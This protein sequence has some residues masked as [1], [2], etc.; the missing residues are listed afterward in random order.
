MPSV[1]P[2]GTLAVTFFKTRGADGLYRIETFLNSMEPFQGHPDFISSLPGD[3][4]SA[5]CDAFSEY[6]ISS[7]SLPSYSFGIPKGF[8]L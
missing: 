7:A 4:G 5:E 2:A 3:V 8:S 1:V 6:N